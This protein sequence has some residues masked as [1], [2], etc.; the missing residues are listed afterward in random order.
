M[1]LNEEQRAQRFSALESPTKARS[2]GAQY[3]V[4]RM[5]ALTWDSQKDGQETMSALRMLGQVLQKPPPLG[6]Q[7]TCPGLLL[8]E[9]A[10]ATMVG[11]PAYLA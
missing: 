9:A 6:D 8:T 4:D 1:Q 2:S 3:G 7:T 10:T 5:S 11:A